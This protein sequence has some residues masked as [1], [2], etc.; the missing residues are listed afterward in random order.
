[1]TTL[2]LRHAA[3]AAAALSVVASA[4]YFGMLGLPPPKGGVAV[5]VGLLAALPVGV[6]LGCLRLLATRRKVRLPE[7]AR[8]IIETVA[9]GTAFLYLLYHLSHTLRFAGPVALAIDTLVPSPVLHLVALLP[10][11]GAAALTEVLWRRTAKGH[12]R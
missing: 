5:V 3:L 9:A 12:G 7:P 11:L 2:Q 4:V 10:G 1:M 6:S 8:S